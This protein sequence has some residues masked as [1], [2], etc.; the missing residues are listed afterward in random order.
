[1]IKDNVNDWTYIWH[2]F[3]QSLIDGYYDC[4]A[5]I[6]YYVGRW[7]SEVS[8]S[9]RDYNM[10]ESDGTIQEGT[11][12]VCIGDGA[13]YHPWQDFRVTLSLKTEILRTLMYCNSSTFPDIAVF[14][15]V[16]DVKI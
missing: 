14:A 11:M 10:V 13:D 7:G 3:P 9:A 15:D 16:Q 2:E 8:V 6:T 12:T 5:E 4:K 1:M